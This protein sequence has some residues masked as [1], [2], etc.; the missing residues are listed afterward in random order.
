MCILGPKVRLYTLINIDDLKLFLSSQASDYR[1]YPRGA[2]MGEED[3]GRLR[4]GHSIGGGPG[5][6]E[7]VSRA[8]NSREIKCFKYY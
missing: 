5:H 8:G 6:H 2:E 3:E 7:S 4:N 1:R